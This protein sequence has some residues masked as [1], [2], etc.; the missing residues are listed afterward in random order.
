MAEVTT[1]IGILL[2]KAGKPGKTWDNRQTHYML[3]PIVMGFCIGR[4]SAADADDKPEEAKDSIE[5]KFK[6]T[7]TQTFDMIYEHFS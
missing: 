6:A 1:V 4:C 3:P 5:A 7:A 2:L